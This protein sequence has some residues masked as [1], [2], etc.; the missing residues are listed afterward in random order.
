MPKLAREHGVDKLARTFSPWSHVVALL[1]AQLAHAL[2]LNDVCDA[3]RLWSTPL[4]AL[5][6]ATP[7]PRNNL[8]HAS[9]TRDCTSGESLFREMLRHLEQSFTSFGRGNSP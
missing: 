9:K 8:S 5:R 7:P 3:L 6:G 1:Y 2:S 4:R